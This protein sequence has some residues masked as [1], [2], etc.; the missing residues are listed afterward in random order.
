MFC[1]LF[2]VG[3]YYGDDMKKLKMGETDGKHVTEIVR[4]PEGMI[5]LGT[6]KHIW[7][8]SVN[9]DLRETGR[10]NFQPAGL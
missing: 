5:P 4:K 6:P 3:Y 9:T 8:T 7:E 10:K 2:Q 1:A